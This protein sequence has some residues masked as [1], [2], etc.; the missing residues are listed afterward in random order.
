MNYRI[1]LIIIATIIISGCRKPYLPPIISSGT[2]YLVVEGAINT[3]Q[4]STIIHLSRTVPL[5]SPSGTMSSPELNASVVVESDANASYP[6]TDAG[7]GY[8]VAAGLNLS[9]S[10]KYRVQITTADS[11]VYQS[12]FVTAKNSPPIDS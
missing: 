8:Y 6:L 7:N 9:A 10:N 11:K 4:D 3:G 2:N 1:Y 12:D 5:S